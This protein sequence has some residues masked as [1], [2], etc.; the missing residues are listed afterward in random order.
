MPALSGSTP[1]SSSSWGIIADCGSSGTRLRLY[2][3]ENTLGASSLN[4]FVPTN[5][6]D[7]EALE[8]N[9]RGISSFVENPAGAK[10][11]FLALL[12]QAERWIPFTEQPNTRVRAYATGGLRTLPEAE[13]APIFAA[14][15]DAKRESNFRFIPGDS[16]TI[17]GECARM[18]PKQSRSKAASR[19]P[20][21]VLLHALSLDVTCPRTAACV[22]DSVPDRTWL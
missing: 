16:V 10:A 22:L 12:V 15:D 8:D 3:W 9:T 13:Q 5:L 19:P 21:C 7:Q 6:V 17:S 1:T 20:S 4:E 2:F 14:I 11:Y 18:R